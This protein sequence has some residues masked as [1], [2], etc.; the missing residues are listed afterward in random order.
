MIL[1]RLTTAVACVPGNRGQLAHDAVDADAHEEPSLLRGEVDVGGAE[2]ERLRD[3]PV[4]ED[5]G[6]RVV[7]RGRERSRRPSLS[8]ASVTTSSIATGGVIVEPVIAASIRPGAATQMR[9]GIPTA[10]RSSSENIT[11]VGS[12]TATST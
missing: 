8:W 4:D 1:R 2:V 6:R 11:L 10:S 3:R 5:D 9:I 7:V 12:A